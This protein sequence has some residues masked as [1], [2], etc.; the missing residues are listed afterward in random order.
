MIKPAQLYKDQLEDLFIETWYKQKYM[1]Y[2][3]WF[4]NDLPNIPDNN[5]DRHD[6]VSVDNYNNI[7]G[8]ISYGINYASMNADNFGII[9]FRNSV[10]FAKDVYEVICDLFYK[11]NMNRISWHVFV[12][13]PA[14]RGYRNFIKKYGGRECAY[15]RQ[16]VK[17][18]DGKLHDDVEFEILKCEFKGKK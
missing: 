7:I 8:Y 14:I 6:F 5:Y 16:V 12:E 9:S 18:Q 4:G 1:Y 11:Y 2:N 10:E 15:R 3:G 13:N 17:L